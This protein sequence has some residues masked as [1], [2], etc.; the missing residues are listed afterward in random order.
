MEITDFFA[1]YKNDKNTINKGFFRVVF[2][3]LK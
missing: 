3:F 1:H 2:Y